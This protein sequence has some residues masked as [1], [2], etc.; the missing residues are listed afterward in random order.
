MLICTQG[1][2]NHYEFERAGKALELIS[3]LLLCLPPEDSCRI[4]SSFKETGACT[5]IRGQ[6]E[7]WS[8]FSH[9][10]LYSACPILVPGETGK[11][12]E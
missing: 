9:I 8:F 7:H 3:S 12:F 1:Q 2:A 10:D 6:R 5:K 4:R 11:G